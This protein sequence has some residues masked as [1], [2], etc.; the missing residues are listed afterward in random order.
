M[1]NELL[2]LA[3]RLRLVAGMIMEDHDL[4]AVGRSENVD[5]LAIKLQAL[6][7]AGSEIATLAAAAQVLVRMG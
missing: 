3:N 5:D 7:T 2:D 6:G 4:T 1:D